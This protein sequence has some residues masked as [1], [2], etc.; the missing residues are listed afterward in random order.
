MNAARLQVLFIVGLL[1]CSGAIA[2]VPVL[3]FTSPRG[4]EA[5]IVGQ[6]QTVRLN[7]KLK[8]VAIELSHDGGATFTALGTID[9]LVKDKTQRNLLKFTVQGP[10]SANCVMRAR[11]QTTK[12]EV[13]VDSGAFSITGGGILTGIGPGDLA[14]GSVTNPKLAPKAVTTDKTN[15]GAASSGM[16]LTADGAG[17]ATFAP[18]V[19]GDAATLSGHPCTDFSLGNHNHFGQVWTGA[20]LTDGLGIQ[21]TTATGMTFGLTGQSDSTGGIGVRGHASATSGATYGVVGTCE[22][23]AGVGVKGYAPATS[24]PTNGVFG[25]CASPDGAG[26]YGYAS[27]SSGVN[28]GVAGGCASSDGTGV[29]GFAPAT[30]GGT[31]GVSGQCASSTGIG[32]SGYALATSGTARGVVG[33]SSS[34]GGAGVY[35]CASATSGENFGVYGTSSSP[36]G[37]AAWFDG[38]VHVNGTLSKAAGTFKIDHPLDPANKYLSHSFVESPEMLNVYN[39]VVSLDGDGTAAVKLPAY[40]EALNR[41][42][43]YQLTP[44]GCSAPGLYV[45]AEVTDNTFTI[46]GGAAGLKVSWQVTGVRK[47][48]YAAAHPVVVEKDKPDGERGLFLNPKEHGQPDE[49]GLDF[50]RRWKQQIGSVTGR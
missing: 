47:D 17:G 7:S 34:P 9:N 37:W 29:F 48:A 14:D 35:G 41:D 19:S 23:D 20:S 36:A 32:V 15:S 33:D 31:Q 24:G 22:S 46:R 12:G 38:Y 42:F 30:S 50:S 4:G 1:L 26:V 43:T 18:V 13:S 40:F 11:G 45:A 39:G 28:S 16:V 2:A 44:V 5:Y 21:N 25:E 8:S 3:E 49:K 27:S 6:G 10:T